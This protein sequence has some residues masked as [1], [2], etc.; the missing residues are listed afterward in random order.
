M[1]KNAF[2]IDPEIE[3]AFTLPSEVYRSE[4]VFSHLKDKLFCQ[5][6]QFAGGDELWGH[7][8]NCHPFEF[9]APSVNEPLL[10]IKNDKEELCLS[11]VC[12]HRG[13]ILVENPAQM[14][15]ITCGYH[16]RCFRLDGTFK[17]MPMFEEAENFPS[18][19]DH[20][21]KFPISR[22][23]AFR[24]VATNPS[25]G[26]DDIFRPLRSL[27]PSYPFGNLMYSSDLSAT[28]NVN[29]NW[30][31]YVDNYLEGFHI[32]FVHKTLNSK[33]AFEN[34]EVR[35]FEYSSVQIAD[36]KAGESSIKL[37]PSDPDYGKQRYA[38]YWF[39][40]PN[41]MINIYSWGVSVNIILPISIEKTRVEFKTYLLPEADADNVKDT[42]LHLTE[43]EDEAVV[44]SVQ[45]GLRSKSY[46]RGRFS[47]A[48]EKAVH[49]FHLYLSRILMAE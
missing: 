18:E 25:T 20:L 13:K 37:M 11:N 21:K 34:Y 5:S 36:A 4:A 26:F 19:S 44:E 22:L 47:P 41:T 49:A 30:L 45:K 42:A 14:R 39:I 48:M 6:W 27:T 16:G 40:Y 23:G 38:Y 7:G 32:P 3:F 17:S 24:F 8:V 15:Q 43:M 31:A 29:A 12:T 1:N 33:I 10:M 46:T 2:Y 28:Y 9:M 35:T